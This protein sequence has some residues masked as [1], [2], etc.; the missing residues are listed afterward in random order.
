ME[1][2]GCS[3]VPHPPGTYLWVGP[4]ARRLRS[5]GSWFRSAPASTQVSVES[6]STLLADGS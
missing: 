1:N 6:Y 2:G 4:H 3:F 5:A